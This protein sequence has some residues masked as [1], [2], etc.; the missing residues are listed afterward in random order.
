MSERT[1]AE[2]TLTPGRLATCW[3]P[4]G[5]AVPM[6]WATTASKMAALRAS[7]SSRAGR[8]SLLSALGITGSRAGLALK[9]TECQPPG[10][11]SVLEAQ[12]RDEGFLGHLHAPDGLH[13]LLAFFLALE[14][15]ALPRDVTAV[16]LGQ[17]V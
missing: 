10:A 3:E 2:E 13:L 7:R 17:D 16:A 15:L 4:T 14:Q 11:G 6:Y 12:G 9:S 1:V 8:L 5:W